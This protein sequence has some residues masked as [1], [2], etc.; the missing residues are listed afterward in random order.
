MIAF[1]LSCGESFDA[2][3]DLAGLYVLPVACADCK[4]ARRLRTMLGI[5]QKT[6]NAYPK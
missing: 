2:P 1:C 5:V 4:D 3:L 6:L